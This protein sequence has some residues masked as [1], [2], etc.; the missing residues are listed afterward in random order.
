M[1]KKELT[2]EQAQNEL[3]QILHL[4]QTDQTGID[5]LADQ[6]KRAKQLIEICRTKLREVEASIESLEE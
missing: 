1:A 3:K 4:I 5:Q 6:I 2:Y